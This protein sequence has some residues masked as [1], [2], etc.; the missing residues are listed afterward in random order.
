QRQLFTSAM[1]DVHVRMDDLVTQADFNALRT[2][3][4]KRFDET[5]QRMDAI[6]ADVS[7][8]LKLLT[9]KPPGPT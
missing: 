4:E 8:I 7:A 6:Q 2:D 5:T 1:S 3:V 9:Q